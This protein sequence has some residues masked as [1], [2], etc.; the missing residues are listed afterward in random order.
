MGK[1]GKHTNCFFLSVDKR[2]IS[3]LSAF[4]S[5]S[6]YWKSRTVNLGHEITAPEVGTYTHT[7]S[8]TLYEMGYVNTMR[9]KWR[10]C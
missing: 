4:I 5:T 9:A 8:K 7:H 6:L 3:S 2:V 10:G 1:K